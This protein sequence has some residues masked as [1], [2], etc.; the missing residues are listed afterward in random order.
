[1]PNVG[2]EPYRNEWYYTVATE[3]GNRRAYLGVHF[4]EGEFMALEKAHALH[5]VLQDS[6][7]G[8]MEIPAGLLF[9][10]EFDFRELIS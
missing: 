4:E 9:D 2:F 5:E 10:Q 3:D 1:M 8:Q 7:E 6:D